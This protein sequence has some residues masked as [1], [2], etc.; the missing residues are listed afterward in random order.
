M[1]VST[2]A[3]VMASRHSSLE[4]CAISVSV[5]SIW[6]RNSATR[7]A[8][9]WSLMAASVAVLGCT[10]TERAASCRPETISQS[11]RIGAVS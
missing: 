5:S 2:C 6:S 11:L 4:Y 1:I 10:T 7:A 3:G 9:L 8:R